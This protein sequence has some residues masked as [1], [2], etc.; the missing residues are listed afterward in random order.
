MVKIWWALNSICLIPPRRRIFLSIR[1]QFYHV[2]CYSYYSSE[3]VT[4][5]V[6][7]NTL[8]RVSRE[9]LLVIWDM[10]EVTS[11][12]HLKTGI[13]I[14]RSPQLLDTRWSRSWIVEYFAWI[15]G[16]YINWCCILIAIDAWLAM[17]LTWFPFKNC[18]F[19]VNDIKSQRSRGACAVYYKNI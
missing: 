2:T 16:I 4:W 8:L 9:L 1:L 13:T 18:Q 19:S 3:G 17:R 15:L 11:A 5:V 14:Q 10:E 12:L 6:T 7:R